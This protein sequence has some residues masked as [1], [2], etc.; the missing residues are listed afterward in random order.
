MGKE[1]FVF[2][3]CGGK[4]HIDTLH[5]SL[6][7]LR[8]FSENEIVVVTDKSRN[9]IEIEHSQIVDV[10]TPLN[11]THHQASIYLKTG[12][13]KF[14]PK[15]NLYCYLDT[16]VVAVSNNCNGIFK[17][18]VSPIRFAA[19]HCDLKAF[20]AYAVNCNC[21]Q[22]NEANRSKFLEELE[23]VDR[24]KSLQ[25]FSQRL[26]RA[27]IQKAYDD[28]GGSL[29]KKLEV[30]IRYKLSLKKF[31]LNESF[32]LNKQAKEWILS[33][34]EVVKYETDYTALERATEIKLSKWKGQW[35][36][37]KNENIF[38]TTCNHLAE[39]ISKTFDI[40]VDDKNFQHW[41]GGVF[42]FNDE[43]EQFLEAWHTKTLKIFDL[44][45]WKTR[46]QGTLIAT[47]W[48]FGLQNHS[49][50]GKEW[51]F[52]ADYYNPKLFCDLKN[53]KI[54][55]NLFETIFEPHFMHIYHHWADQNWDVWN[56]IENK[57]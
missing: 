37:S 1:I 49:V 28:L 17:E 43:S 50:L 26:N 48:E 8:K 15:G 6:K 11:Y 41:N 39:Q 38:D 2:V 44:K 45:Y 27:K 18:F 12:I 20:S 40:T 22:K 42:L 35:L 51:N 10:K 32:T 24:N 23:K 4:E 34:G 53:N 31:R 30:A 16:D 33:S 5:F 3:V 14:V 9:E 7:Y 25:S 54:S 36:N 46:D 55:D 56:W 21:L 29:L 19:D 13:H 52:I 57:K 47:V